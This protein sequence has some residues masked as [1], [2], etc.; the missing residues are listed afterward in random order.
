[1]KAFQ[2]GIHQD[3]RGGDF[4]GLSV[5]GKDPAVHRDTGDVTAAAAVIF[6]NRPEDIL[7][8]YQNG[9]GGEEMELLSH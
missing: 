7:S 3:L 5:V 1:M 6:Q 2:N 8:V 4:I 9:G